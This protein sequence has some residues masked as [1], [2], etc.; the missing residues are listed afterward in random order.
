MDNDVPFI[1][2][3]AEDKQ[4]LQAAY[5][6][7]RQYFEPEMNIPWDEWAEI[8]GYVPGKG[9]WSMAGLM[10]FREHGY[11]VVHIA[12]FDYVDFALRGPEYL[13]EALDEEIAQWDIKF[14]DFELEQA[15]ATRFLHY[16]MWVRRVPTISDI[17]YHMSNGYL[18][19][20]PVNLKALNGEPGYLSHAV[21]VK[22]MTDS[23]VILHDPG[24]PARPD[25]HV[26]L[27]QFLEAW[28]HPLSFGEEKLDAIRKVSESPIKMFNKPAKPDTVAA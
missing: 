7:I 19:K 12:D 11:E 14:T 1:S 16:G 6:M 20:C 26:P 18:V 10:W 9:T 21:V 15:R 5:A 8:T 13:V 28:G 3:T 22:G 25:R 23:E 4:C 27:G 24:L 2:N 17:R